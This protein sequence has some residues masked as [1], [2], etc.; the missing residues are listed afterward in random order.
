MDVIAFIGKVNS[1]VGSCA[2]TSQ[3]SKIIAPIIA[4]AGINILWFEVENNILEICG[5]AKPT[6]AI[7]P[8]KA[9]ITPVNKLVISKIM[10]LLFLILIP[11]LFA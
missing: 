6:K 5:I 7:G 10:F 11:K 2:I 3:I 1:L 9:V 8:E 4:T